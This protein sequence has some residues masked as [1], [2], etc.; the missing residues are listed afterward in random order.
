MGAIEFTMPFMPYGL[1]WRAH[2]RLFHDFIDIS[3]A[4]NY[5][6]NQIKVVSNFLVHLH[7]EPKAFREHIELCA[8]HPPVL[9]IRSTSYLQC[10]LQAH[11]FVGA[12]DR[13]RDPGRHPGQRVF[14]YV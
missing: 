2:R 13:V 12:L 11:R 8:P 4:E 5:D 10:S 7:K 9:L 1:R 6:V 3:T 14:S